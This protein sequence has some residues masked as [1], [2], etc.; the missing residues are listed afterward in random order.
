M[1]W[2]AFWAEEC[3]ADDQCG[4]WYCVEMDNCM[5]EETWLVRCDD[6]NPCTEDWCEPDTGCHHGPATTPNPSDGCD[7]GDPCTWE[8]CEDGH[9]AYAP[10]CSQPGCTECDTDEDCTAGPP[11]STGV[12]DVHGCQDKTC[13]YILCDDD[14]PCTIDE[15][16]GDVCTH[17]ERSCDIGNA[18]KVGSC[19]PATGVCQYE[20]RPEGWPCE[21]DGNPCTRDLCNANGVCIHPPEPP[22]TECP[23]WDDG[24]VCTRE[25]CLEGTCQHPLEPEGKPCPDEDDGNECT[26]EECDAYGVCQHPPVQDGMYCEADLDLCTDDSCQSGV[27]VSI[28]KDCDDDD[29][30]TGDYCDEATG[31]CMHDECQEIQGQPAPGPQAD[32]RTFVAECLVWGP[33]YAQWSFSIDRYVGETDEVFPQPKLEWAYELVQEGRLSRYATLRIDAC[34]IDCSSSDDCDAPNVVSFNGTPVDQLEAGLNPFPCL[35]GSCLGCSQTEFRIPIEK[36]GFPAWP[37]YPPARP[38]TVINNVD[39]DF[40][41]GSD[42]RV[43]AYATLEIEAMSPIILVHGNNSDPAFFDRQGFTSFLEGWLFMWNGIYREDLGPGNWNDLRVELPTGPREENAERL[44]LRVPEIVNAFGVDSIHIVAHSKGG[45]D[46]RE[47]LERFYDPAG[48]FEVLSLTTLSTPHNGSAG[49]DLL[50]AMKD[51]SGSQVQRKYSGFPGF[52]PTI[53]AI[54]PH[55]DGVPD[56]ITGNVASF[57]ASNIARLPKNIFYNAVGGDADSNR[58]RDLLFPPDETAALRVEK[59]GLNALQALIGPWAVSVIF[60]RPYQYLRKVKTVTVTNVPQQIM[61]TAGSKVIT[62]SYITGL[63]TDTPQLNDILVTVRSAHGRGSYAK[64]INSG[65]GEWRCYHSLLNHASVGDSRVAG[66]VTEK[67]KS[68]E[69]TKGDLRAR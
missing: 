13:R 21:E 36:V 2:A 12:C 6:G 64:K 58:D 62:R 57:N 28:P 61:T 15:C 41:G 27:C 30:C 35:T 49:A 22:G 16:V 5:Y 32:D 65:D 42:C 4:R 10:E 69:Q 52:G 17:E 7:D 8:Y 24:T 3:L 29:P 45:L 1:M 20:D 37:G 54:L 14:N 46:T 47:Y 48:P 25:E 59:P 67:L 11:C 19:D 60:D 23:E 33:T 43:F 50:Q 34:G 63:P 39:V 40:A 26:N 68:I 55:D 38:G 51:N 44:G 18:C 56:L 53:A 31:L 66:W 9:C